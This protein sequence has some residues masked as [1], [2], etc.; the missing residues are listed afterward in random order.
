MIFLLS[1]SKIE[2]ERDRD[3]EMTQHKMRRK[4]NERNHIKQ[5]T[6]KILNG[7]PHKQFNPANKR[8]IVGKKNY[9]AHVSCR[10]ASIRHTIVPTVSWIMAMNIKII[11]LWMIELSS[12]GFFPVLFRY[13]HIYGYIYSAVVLGGELMIPWTNGFFLTFCTIDYSRCDKYTPSMIFE[14][15]G[16]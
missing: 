13:L 1:E 15:Y 6:I 2:K 16:F 4:I 8:K 7:V 12:F 10:N 11:I 9:M 14:H 3:R 5:K